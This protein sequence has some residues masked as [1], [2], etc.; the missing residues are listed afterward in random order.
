MNR[1]QRLG[2]IAWLAFKAA[3]RVRV[4]LGPPLDF[5]R[6]R[7][8]FEESHFRSASHLRATRRPLPAP[9]ATGTPVNESVSWKL[10]R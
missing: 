2:I 3:A 9:S 8:D 1:A 10:W 6:L 7:F 5:A 4:P